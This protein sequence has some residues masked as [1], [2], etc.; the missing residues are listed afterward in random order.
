MAVLRKDPNTWTDFGKAVVV[1]EI[2]GLYGY[3]E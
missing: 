1:G 2:S 3:D